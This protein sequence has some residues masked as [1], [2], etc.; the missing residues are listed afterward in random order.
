MM[1]MLLAKFY[2]LFS[3]EIKSWK[4]VAD[5]EVL[6]EKDSGEGEKKKGESILWRF[7]RD[8]VHLKEEMERLGF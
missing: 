1:L 8:E 2:G 7:Q 5:R 4:L 3:Q 6:F